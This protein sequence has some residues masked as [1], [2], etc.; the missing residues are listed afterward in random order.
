MGENSAVQ[1]GQLA[2]LEA[3]LDS[4]TKRSKWGQSLD[5][6]ATREDCSWETLVSHAAPEVVQGV[7]REMAAG[8]QQGHRDLKDHPEALAGAGGHLQTSILPGRGVS[9]P[10]IRFFL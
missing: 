4:L 3:M 9:C 6:A 5:E 7:S 10:S 2:A 1:P 8:M